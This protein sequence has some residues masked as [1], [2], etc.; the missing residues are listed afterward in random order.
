MP[1]DNYG[2]ADQ[3]DTA[4]NAVSRGDFDLLERLLIDPRS[5]TPKDEKTVAEFLGLK[6]GFLAAALRGK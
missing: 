3:F 5:V 4:M 2:L 1:A 6:R